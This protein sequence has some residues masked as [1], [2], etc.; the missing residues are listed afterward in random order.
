M[1]FYGQIW[2]CHTNQ[3]VAEIDVIQ[4]QFGMTQLNKMYTFC[5]N[6]LIDI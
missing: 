6:N 2:M 3:W 5:D 1:F 4:S